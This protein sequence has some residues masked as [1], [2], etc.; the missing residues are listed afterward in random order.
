MLEMGIKTF[1][2]LYAKWLNFGVIL[3]RAERVDTYLV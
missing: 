3:N 1:V 2:A